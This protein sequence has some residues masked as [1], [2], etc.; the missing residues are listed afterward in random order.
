MWG[1]HTEDGRTVV[2][3][4]SQRAAIEL[5]HKAGYAHITAYQFRTYAF[6]TRDRVELAV[7]TEPG[8]WVTPNRYGANIESFSRKV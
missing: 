3:A 8:V 5:L 4:R 6:L 7:A 2:C 1:L